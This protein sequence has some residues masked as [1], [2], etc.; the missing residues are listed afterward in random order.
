MR[1]Q[2]TIAVA[3]VLAGMATAGAAAAAWAGAPAPGFDPI[4]TRQAGQDLVTGSFIGMR[5]AVI[6]KLPVRPF[7]GTAMAIAKWMQQ[8][9]TL[10]PAGSDRGDNT[11]A[12]GAIWKDRA[13]FDKDADNASAAARKLALLAKA[14]NGPGFAAQLKV[15]GGTCGTCHKQFRAR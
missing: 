8:F 5:Q 11:K 3:V 14:D 4:R 12:L 13:A 7:A 6:H 10:F 1:R 15:L 2:T 9:P